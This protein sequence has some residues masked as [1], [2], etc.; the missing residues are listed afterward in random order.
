MIIYW[1]KMRF[2]FDNGLFVIDDNRV[3]TEIENV[4]RNDGY[5]DK[6]HIAHIV[7]EE[8]K[9]LS[10]R[11]NI[12]SENLPFNIHDGKLIPCKNGVVIRSNM[13]F[14]PN[15]P[16]FG[17]MYQ[18]QAMYNPS[19]SPEPIEKFI[20]DIVDGDDRKLLVQVPAQALMQNANYQLSYCLI[21]DGS[22]GKSTYIQL[23]KELV[24]KGSTTSVS[25]QELLENR[26]ASANLQGKLFN[27]YADLPKTSL[28]DTGKFKILTGGDQISA[29][30]KFCDSF[31][32]E[33]K[34]V[35]VF[36]ANEL[37]TVDDGTFAFWRRWAIIEFPYKF[38]VSNRFIEELIT[39]ENLSGFLNIVIE[40]MNRIEN[41][42]I[43]RSSK[44][45]EIMEIWKMRSNSAYAFIKTRLKKSA[46]EWIPKN[47]LWSEYN[48]YCID[49]DL[50]EMSKI[51][52]RQQLEKEF[53]ISE[54]YVQKDREREIV[55][56]GIAFKDLNALKQTIVHTTQEKVT[57]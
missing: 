56:K 3:E 24:G 50:T 26:F 48:K 18:L 35:F 38:K 31:L 29:E 10:W 32:L 44:A 28:K 6:K 37:P 14:V 9:K 53:L 57:V 47:V 12:N 34:A 16:S 33:N 42:G 7:T 4:L 1:K 39:P 52:F 17:F 30:R 55:V 54:T 27:L 51:K 23:I 49:N 19:D 21:G 36:S 43:L 45:E 25:L 13:D 20:N 2:V 8:I 5:S 22:N 11:C 40:A 41:E 15:S 46:A